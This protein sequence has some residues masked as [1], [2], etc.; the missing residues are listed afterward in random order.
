M[1]YAAKHSNSLGRTTLR[2]TSSG[3]EQGT[4]KVV[5]YIPYLYWS[6]KD[7]PKPNPHQQWNLLL[8]NRNSNTIQ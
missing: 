5:N 6:R 7:T 8:F 3:K 4:D 2:K 1:L